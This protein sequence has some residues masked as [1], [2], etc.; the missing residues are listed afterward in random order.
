M[1]PYAK[2]ISLAI[3]GLA[4][5]AVISGI[6]F[7]GYSRSDNKWTI[8]FQQEK[9]KQDA[10]IQNAMKKILEETQKSTAYANQ[11]E[12]MFNDKS[13]QAHNA[14]INFDTTRVQQR[15]VCKNRLPKNNDT[16]IHATK[17]SEVDTGFS[18]EFRAFLNSEAI[19]DA[20][21]VAWIEGA[22]DTVAKWCTDYADTFICE[23]KN[24]D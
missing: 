17:T 11:I 19:R 9:I 14:A 4:I 8:R 15:A 10:M 18:D 22:S 6:Y 5:L 2:L 1:I 13:N 12:A 23:A 20:I 24:A 16:S 7:A 3:R 21:N